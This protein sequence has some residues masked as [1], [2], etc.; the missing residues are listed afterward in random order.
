M[1]KTRDFLGNYL[2]SE[3]ST[4]EQI[5]ADLMES[6]YGGVKSGLAM[7][8]DRVQNNKKTVGM[9]AIYQEIHRLQP[10]ISPISVYL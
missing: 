10:K 4:D 3:G 5:L 8:I 6:G 2:I 7:N 1:L 9:W